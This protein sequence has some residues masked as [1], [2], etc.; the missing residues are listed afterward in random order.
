M[1]ETLAVA[2]IPAII[3]SICKKDCFGC[4][5]SRSSGSTEKNDFKKGIVKTF[6][7]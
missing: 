4:D 6:I 5:S 3:K 1:R 7:Y 2:A